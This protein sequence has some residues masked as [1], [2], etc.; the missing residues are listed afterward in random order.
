MA[1]D[2]SSLMGRW[3]TVRRAQAIRAIERAHGTRVDRR[4]GICRLHKR[5]TWKRGPAQNVLLL[6]RAC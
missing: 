4:L 1:M 3:Y 5:Q 2:F 6:P